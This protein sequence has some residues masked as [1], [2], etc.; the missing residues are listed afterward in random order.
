VYR[1][2]AF[3]VTDLGELHRLIE[4]SG[5]AHLVSMTP[6]GLTASVVPLLLERGSGEHGTLVGHLARVN[7]HWRDVR[8][9]IESMAIFAGPDAYISPNWYATKGETGRVVPTWN[10]EVIHAHGELVVHDDPVWLDALVRR[11]TDRH[12]AGLPKPWS[13]DDAPADYAAAQ[14]RAIVG[15]ELRITR[16]EGKRKLSQNRSRP[17]VEGAIAGLS[18]GTPSEQQIADRMSQALRRSEAAG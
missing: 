5:P 8:P 7:R 2:K 4:G 13:V 1:P 16:L 10:Y 14:L 9:G 17:D 3:D 11:L 6:T 18:N 15:I 12:E